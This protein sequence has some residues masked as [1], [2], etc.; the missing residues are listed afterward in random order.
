V[1]SGGFETFLRH[2]E[3]ERLRRVNRQEAGLAKKTACNEAT[4]RCRMEGKSSTPH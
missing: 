4:G 3:A 2:E 1:G